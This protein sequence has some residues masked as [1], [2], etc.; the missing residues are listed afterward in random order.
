MSDSGCIPVLLAHLA[1]S[2]GSVQLL[3]EVSH[4]EGLGSVHLLN[5]Y[6]IFLTQ[7]ASWSMVKQMCQMTK[8]NKR[9]TS[10]WSL[11]YKKRKLGITPGFRLG[12][13]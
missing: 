2:K 5:Y 7:D 1:F 4:G 8:A 9:R 11:C 3:L 12:I 13:L 10:P 6:I